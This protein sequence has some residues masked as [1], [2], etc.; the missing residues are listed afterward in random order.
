MEAA[1]GEYGDIVPNLVVALKSGTCA[2]FQYLKKLTNSEKDNTTKDLD[3]KERGGYPQLSSGSS[4]MNHHNQ[5]TAAQNTA[6][7][8]VQVRYYVYYYTITSGSY[9]TPCN[10]LLTSSY[11]TR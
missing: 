8:L 3:I 9:P 4:M 10:P 2:R 1:C 5:N 6:S 7:H 11:R